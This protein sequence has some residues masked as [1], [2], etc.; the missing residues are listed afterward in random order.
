MNKCK[1]SLKIDT[2]I[3]NFY[4]IIVI[5]MY[6]KRYKIVEIIDYY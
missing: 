5:I 2:E 4:T 1:L 6:L 3:Y